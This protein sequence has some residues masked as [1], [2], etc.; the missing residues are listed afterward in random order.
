[1]GL[2]LYP[3]QC[4][5]IF[6]FQLHS[7][8]SALKSYPKQMTDPSSRQRGRA[9]STK[10]QPSDSDKNLVLGPRWG[11]TPRLTGRLTVS[12]NVTL[13]KVM[14]TIAGRT[15]YPFAICRV[16]VS[17]IIPYQKVML[18]LSLIKH[19]ALKTYGGVE[20]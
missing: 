17:G 5:F 14:Q 20:V 18:S 12:R 11:L 13:T 9:T 7:F 10:P 19:H 3:R 6:T 2:L 4:S 15:L 1:M 16:A 8:S